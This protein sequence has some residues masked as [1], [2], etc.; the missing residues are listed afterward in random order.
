MAQDKLIYAAE[1]GSLSFGDCEL[2]AK[3]KQE[4]SID[5][6]Q[7]KVKTFKEITKLEKNEGFVYESVPG[8]I[9]SNFRETENG[10]SFTVKGD[11]DAQ[12]ILG[13][14]DNADYNVAVDGRNIGRVSTGLGGKL[15]IS[16]E[17]AGA[18]SMTVVVSK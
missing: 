10:I 5:G 3:K 18:D 16:L 17:L 13:L 6:D 8:T 2:P 4:V 12:I 9:V 1:D 15:S 11:E 14:E 7:Y